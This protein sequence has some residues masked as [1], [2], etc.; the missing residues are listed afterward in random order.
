M[1]IHI[2]LKNF[3]MEFLWTDSYEIIL[4]IK[5]EI[6]T[7]SMIACDSFFLFFFFINLFKFHHFVNDKHQLVNWI[8]NIQFSDKS[9]FIKCN[10][11]NKMVSSTT[12]NVFDIVVISS[13]FF[14][15]S[16]IYFCFCY[17]FRC[18]IARFPFA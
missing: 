9:L 5:I 8:L 2:A 11:A 4:N 12:N 17:D 7:G 16:L 10:W 1:K 13:S 14:F 15:F 6:V 18:N 3:L